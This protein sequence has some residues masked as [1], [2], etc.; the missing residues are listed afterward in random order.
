MEEDFGLAVGVVF[1]AYAKAVEAAAAEVPGGSRGYLVLMAAVRGEANGQRLLAERLG[2]D[3]TVMTYLLDD[4]ERADL[5]ERRP[6]PADRR[7]RRIVA[8]EHG[9]RRWE[10]LRGRVRG[11]EDQLLGVLPEGVRDQ[12]RA[13]LCAVA[14]HVNAEDPVAHACQVAAELNISQ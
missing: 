1:R 3:R 12:F 5:V 13:M 2:V 7:S 10:E 9:A 8:T 4:M 14:S 11:V 6:D